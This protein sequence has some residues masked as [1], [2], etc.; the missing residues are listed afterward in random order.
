MDFTKEY[1]KA[2]GLKP[3][4]NNNRHNPLTR[5]PHFFIVVMLFFVSGCSNSCTKAEVEDTLTQID[6]IHATFTDLNNQ[7]MNHPE[8]KP[9]NIEKM[10]S[11]IED[12]RSTELPK[13]TKKLSEMVLEAMQSSV[14]YLSPP[15]GNFYYPY[16]LAK[17]AMDD[18]DSVEKEMLQIQNELS[19]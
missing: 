19:E 6:T 2:R 16:Q 7:S 14:D 13:C 15:A 5:L 10:D 17:F 12:F 18:W 3:M 9:A 8:N 4:H 11:M 1:K